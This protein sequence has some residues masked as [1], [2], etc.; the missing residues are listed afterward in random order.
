M[1]R[2]A[3]HFCVMTLYP[4]TLLNSCILKNFFVEFLRLSTYKIF[5]SINRFYFFLS[6]LDAFYFCRSM[7]FVLIAVLGININRL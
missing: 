1:C 6:N 3:T 5:S 4:A 2:N 7:G